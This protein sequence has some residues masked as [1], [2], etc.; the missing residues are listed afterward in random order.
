VFV[1]KFCFATVSSEGVGNL[2]W[3]AW[4]A[5]DSHLVLLFYDD[6]PDSWP[7]VYANKDNL[8]CFTKASMAQGNRSII[9]NEL[10]YQ[11]FADYI[12]PHFWYVVISNCGGTSQMEFEYEMEFTNGGGSW[13]VQFSYDEQSVPQM[14]LFFWLLFTI[15][16]TI[17]LRG[18][19][20]LRQQAAF[21]PIIR[22]LTSSIVLETVSELCLFI[23]YAVYKTNGIGAPGLEGLG[24]ILNMISQ[25]V[26]MFLLLLLA[27]GWAITKTEV[28]DKKFLIVMVSAF[29]L[30]Y[31]T[32]FIWENVGQ[33]PAST[34]Y[35]YESAPGIIILVL[36]ALT[37]LWFLFELRRTHLEE[38]NPE[39]RRFYIIFGISYTLWF[40]ALPFIVLLAVLF[41]PW[42]RFKVVTGLFL[43]VNSIGFFGLAFLFWPSRATRFFSITKTDLL[44]GKTT[45]P[46]ET[47]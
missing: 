6:V 18:V 31:I 20:I 29:L 44:L 27:K 39:K 40:L 45:S 15:G 12:R 46:Y 3:T 7:A 28:S 13:D 37:L 24:E 32:M 22:L 21:H 4:S 8:D 19:W 5:D 43:C 30:A 41:A 2:T 34:L 47:L 25:L 42:Y 38:D 11:E 17:H 16:L 9:T 36:R 14:Y 35:V 33:D 23:H 1:G 10:D 26:F